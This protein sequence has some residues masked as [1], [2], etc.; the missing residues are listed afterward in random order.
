MEKT[1]PLQI[2][3]NCSRKKC[4]SELRD[5]SH[6]DRSRYLPWSADCLLN[7]CCPNQI[8]VTNYRYT[9][10]DHGVGGNIGTYQRDCYL[11][12]RRDTFFG[13]NLRLFAT[14]MFFHFF[15]LQFTIICNGNVFSSMQFSVMTVINI[16]SIKYKLSLIEIGSR[17]W[18]F[19]NRLHVSYG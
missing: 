4:L 13:Y 19:Y 17:S 15:R 8:I 7:V 1:F 14:E 12:I 6:V 18:K 9:Q 3:V 2:I 11:L 10:V 5:N 16:S